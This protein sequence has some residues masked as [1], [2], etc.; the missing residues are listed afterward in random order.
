MQRLHAQ[1]RRASYSD[2]TY[3]FPVDIP[4]SRAALAS[5]QL[6]SGSGRAA[7]GRPPMQGGRAAVMRCVCCA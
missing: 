1:W 7:S 4:P 2:V 5:S 3:H 6:A